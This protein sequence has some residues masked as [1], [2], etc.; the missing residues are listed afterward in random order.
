MKVF[1]T[2]EQYR[3]THTQLVESNKSLAFV[4]TM[5]ALH[6]GHMA[7]IRQAAALADKV[8]VSIFVNPTQFNDAQD[9]EKYPRPL[10]ADIHLLTQNQVDMLFLPTVDEVYPPGQDLSVALDLSD[11]TSPL[12]GKFR[13]GHF[14]GVVTVVHRLLDITQPDYLVMG[15]KD[16]QQQTIVAE[17]IRQLD[18]PVQLVCHRIM[19]ES[20]GLALSSRNRRIDPNLRPKAS[21][22]YQAL[23]QSQEQMLATTPAEVEMLGRAYLEESG[24]EVE[25]YQVVDGFRLTRVKDWDLPYIVVCVAAWLGD[26][27]LIDNLI[28][29]KR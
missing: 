5:G 26:I 23:L 27:R 25:Y 13:P 18:W 19:R 1:T 21:A 29:K 22:I 10:G 8:V 4:P 3:Q 12:E 24:F 28:L 11:L 7:L 6:Q 15:Q 17:M 9:L 2:V 20:D 16:F 14:D